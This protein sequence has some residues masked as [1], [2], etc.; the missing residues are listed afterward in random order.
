MQLY[1]SYGNVISDQAALQFLFTWAAQF[2]WCSKQNHS[3][4]NTTMVRHLLMSNA[5]LCVFPL[6]ATAGRDLSTLM[7][8]GSSKSPPSLAPTIKTTTSYHQAI[9]CQ[10]GT[11]I[12]TISV[13]GREKN[14]TRLFV[15]NSFIDTLRLRLKNTFNLGA[16]NNYSVFFLICHLFCTYSWVILSQSP[17]SW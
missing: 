2:V 9:Y 13:E 1:P 17:E 6:A 14:V 7:Y 15:G 5:S 3:N 10:L 12:Q 4:L 8:E 16:W 11:L